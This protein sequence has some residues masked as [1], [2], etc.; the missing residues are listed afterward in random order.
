ML[1]RFV[2]HVS[3][4]TLRV[5]DAQK[6]CERISDDNL[7]QNIA[8]HVD[9]MN[10]SLDVTNVVAAQRKHLI[11]GRVC[12]RQLFWTDSED[13]RKRRTEFDGHIFRHGYAEAPVSFVVAKLGPI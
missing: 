5:N 6:R 9:R 13:R 1:E 3:V 7:F 11:T 10:S 12:Q 4:Y 8:V 2:A